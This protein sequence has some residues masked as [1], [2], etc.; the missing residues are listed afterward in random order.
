M[1]SLVPGWLKLTGVFLY[2]FCLKWLPLL[3]IAF[4]SKNVLFAF[5][6][7][8]IFLPEIGLLLSKNFRLWVKTG[9]EDN[10]GQFNS[11]DLA[12]LLRH[13][14]TL[15]CARLYVLFGLIEVFYHI[16]VREVFVMGS[17]AGA[18]GLEAAGL[19]IN[20]KK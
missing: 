10:D 15:W 16:Q 14:S 9:I 12:G 13:Y 19:F 17:L 11:S 18:F 6:I 3:F 2:T 7:L 4:N 1:V 20:K 5:F 8:M